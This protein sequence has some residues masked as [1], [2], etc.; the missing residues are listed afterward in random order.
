MKNLKLVG[1]IIFCIPLVMFGIGHFG[2]AG[3]M[4]GMVPI[5]FAQTFWV[6]LTGAALL[7]AA[8]GILFNI[9]AKLASLLLAVMLL[10]FAFSIHL[11]GMMGGDMNGMANFMK[12]LGMAGGALFISGS[13]KG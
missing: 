9:Q 3:D 6:Y 1:K 13:S 5:P 10:I 11:P 4:A 7:A 2:N 12:D 8:V